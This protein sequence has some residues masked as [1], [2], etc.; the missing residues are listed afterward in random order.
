MLLLTP[1]LLIINGI[2][3]IRKEGRSLAD[4]LS[5]LLGIGIEIGELAL[6]CDVIF[7]YSLGVAFFEK[8]NG[9]LMF[10]GISVF[11]FSFLILLFVLYMAYF[12]FIPHRNDF[13]YIII[14]GCGLLDG[15]RV[16]KLLGSRI[17]KAI[18]IFHKGNDRAMFIC[19]GGKGDDESIP[20]AQA[21]ASYLKEKGIG[22]DHILLEDRSVSTRENLLFSRR[23]IENRGGSGRVALVSSDYHIYRCILLAKELGISCTGI[24]ARTAFYYWPSAVIREFIA[25]YAQK[26]FLFPVLAGYILVISPFIYVLLHRWR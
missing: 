8:I 6:I 14:H 17:D 16:S 2:T 5:L 23:I 26:E 19:S 7:N 15:E 12:R 18:S 3:M 4:L 25:V 10:V 24:G 22:E 9:L 13:D 1:F 20:E 11:Y 21:I